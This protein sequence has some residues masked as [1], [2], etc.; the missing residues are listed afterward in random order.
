M[1]YYHPCSA[2]AQPSISHTDFSVYGLEADSTLGLQA[3]AHS[4]LPAL[5]GRT[6]RFSPIPLSI[7]AA[8]NETEKKRLLTLTSTSNKPKT[9]WGN[10]LLKGQE[11]GLPYSV[12]SC[13]L[14]ETNCTFLWNSRFCKSYKSRRLLSVNH[15]PGCEP[16]FNSGRIE[17][18]IN[19]LQR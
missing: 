9:I 11:N 13:A 15:S 14:I 19:Y 18:S 1:V 6:I 16:R 2:S 12:I 8:S 10:S 17:N 5:L 3:F 7:L 4:I